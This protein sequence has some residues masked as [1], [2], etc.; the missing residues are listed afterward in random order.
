MKLKHKVNI[1][2]TKKNWLV[3]YVPLIASLI[4]M[5]LCLV[6]VIL[7]VYYFMDLELT[8]VMIEI[9]KTVL[10]GVVGP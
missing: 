1:E 3:W 10:E 2:A 5:I 6:A 4:T 9:N 8:T 7:C